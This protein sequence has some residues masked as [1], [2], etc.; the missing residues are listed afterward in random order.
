MATPL[1]ENL[2]ALLALQQ[3]DSHIGRVRRAM[4]GLDDG[5]QAAAAARE[6][7]AAAKSRRDTLHQLSGDLKDSELK[8][9]GV[10]SKQKNYQQRL[11]QGTVTNPKEL[12]N[13]EREIEALGRQR[14]DL[15]GRILDLMEQV[16]TAQG[17][18][19]AADAQ[20]R[21]AEAHLTETVAAF[22][23]RHRTLEQDLADAARRRSEAAGAVTDKALLKRY[24]DI[25]AR[26]GG[27]GIVRIE[28]TD[29]G[30]CHMVLPASQI[31]AVRE[32]QAPQACENCGRLL[33]P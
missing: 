21:E 7:Q 2:G 17:E 28:G 12:S 3:I 4:A 31:K 13:I 6:A 1:E 19:E 25:R 15:D 29:C 33:A 10:E 27:L 20:A 30:G 11:Y 26:P 8:L 32:M 16:E 24:E 18:A 9:S 5:T 14:S 23:S 22:Q